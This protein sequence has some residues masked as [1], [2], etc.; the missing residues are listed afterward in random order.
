MNIDVECIALLCLILQDTPRDR[1]YILC[2][3]ARSNSLPSRIVFHSNTDYP[4]FYGYFNNKIPHYLM[5][6]GVISVEK[7]ATQKQ[8]PPF[9][10]TSIKNLDD[11]AMDTLNESN[12]EEKR[13]FLQGVLESVVVGNANKVHVKGYIP[14]RKEAQ[15][16]QFQP[17]YRDSWI[18]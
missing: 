7:A 4:T 10:L 9:D 11:K 1:Q 8:N 18:T 16:V 12:L 15:N 5:G 13:V 14:A 3:L 2:V 17:I 6:Q